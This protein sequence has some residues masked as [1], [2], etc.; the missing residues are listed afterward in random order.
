[1]RRPLK[2][3][4][5]GASL[6][7]AMFLLT[8]AAGAQTG[9]SEGLL[10]NSSQEQIRR[11]S[12]ELRRNTLLTAYAVGWNRFYGAGEESKASKSKAEQRGDKSGKQGFHN[13]LEDAIRKAD[14]DSCVKLG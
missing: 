4:I 7:A 10:L 11:L 6:L 5:Q 12:I 2:R 1:M 8:T 9:G 3:C 14:R 13:K